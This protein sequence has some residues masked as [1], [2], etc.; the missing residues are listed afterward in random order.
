VFRLW[1]IERETAE[2]VAN[3]DAAQLDQGVA[4]TN[5]SGQ[6]QRI[7]PLWQL[8]VHQVNHATQH[9]SEIAAMLTHFGH[10]PGELDFLRYLQ[11]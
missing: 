5:T 6:P 1:E 2:F 8:M 10:S 9:R 3:L 7:L 4:Y 11:R